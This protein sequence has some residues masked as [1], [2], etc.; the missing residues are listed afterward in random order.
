[1]T[2]SIQWTVIPQNTTRPQI[3]LILVG[4]RPSG[5]GGMNEVC[6]VSPLYDLRDMNLDGTA[7]LTEKLWYGVTKIKDREHVFALIK[8]AGK[9]S[10]VMEAARQMN[11]YFLV[12]AAM[13]E[14][15]EQVLDIAVQSIMPAVIQNLAVAPA[16][17]AAAQ[18]G[19]ATATNVYGGALF[20]VKIGM[21][22]PVQQSL[23]SLRSQRNL[24]G[25]SVGH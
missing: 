16:Q 8:S 24:N 3:N 21:G 2:N 14:A 13:R 5:M 7:S 22:A 15:L 6:A 25:I 19:L 4:Y 1:M 11:D 23:N 20:L 9:L 17:K 18:T 10:C 12:E